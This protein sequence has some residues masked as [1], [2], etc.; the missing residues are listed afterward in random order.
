MVF[1]VNIPPGRNYRTQ[2]YMYCQVSGKTFCK[3]ESMH[4]VSIGRNI[5]GLWNE[6][7][8]GLIKPTFSKQTD[9][10]YTDLGLLDLGIIT[11]TGK[12]DLNSEIF[13]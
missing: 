10:F 13:F 11:N 5:D 1:R 12:K 6:Y 8:L 9:T 3:F 2:L 4:I 7:Q